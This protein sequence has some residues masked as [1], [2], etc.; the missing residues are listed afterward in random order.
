MKI[1]NFENFPSQTVDVYIHVLIRSTEYWLFLF[2]L[3]TC[4]NLHN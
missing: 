4:E 3:H 1:G 2:N